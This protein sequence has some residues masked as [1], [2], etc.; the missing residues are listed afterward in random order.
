MTNE[1]K[2][3][4]K[5]HPDEYFDD[6]EDSDEDQ[7]TKYQDN[8]NLFDEEAKFHSVAQ[9]ILATRQALAK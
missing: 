8:Y 5:L 6:D 9:E 7:V 3:S 1:G 4:I 2:L